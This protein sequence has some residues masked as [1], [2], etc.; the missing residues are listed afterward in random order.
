MKKRFLA[1]LATGLL[2]VGMGGVAEAI[3][4]TFY[5]ITN[6]GDADLS[7]QLL[8]DVSE[9]GGEAVF[10]FTNDV[11]T[12][13]SIAQI[14]FD[15]ISPWMVYDR[16]IESSGVDFTFAYQT[17]YPGNQNLPSG[18]TIG[19]AADSYADGEPPVAQN[20]IDTAA[21]YLKIVFDYGSGYN[22]DSVI[23]AINSGGLRI[24]LHV[25]AIEKTDTY[26]GYSDSYVNTPVP[27]PATMLLFGTGLAGL[28][29]IARRRKKA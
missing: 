29:G 5:N 8:V 19:F 12:P 13:S 20:G 23:N 3:P 15:S 6:N 26:G 9:V 16:L 17:T 25:Q 11:G 2:V 10:T 28:A 14:Y 1:A 22:F 24:G 27:E 18:N 7:T 4:Y 21:E